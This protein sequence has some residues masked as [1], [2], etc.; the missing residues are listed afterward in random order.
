MNSPNRNLHVSLVS[1]RTPEITFDCVI[2]IINSFE[3]QK[4]FELLNIYIADVS[5]NGHGSIIKLDGLLAGYGFESGKTNSLISYYF[6]NRT[7]RLKLND[8][9]NKGFGFA[10]NSNFELIQYEANDK[11]VV[12]ILN[13]DTKIDSDCINHIHEAF[14]F[15]DSKIF[16]CVLIRDDNN[17][18]QCVGGTDE[19]SWKTNGK[20]VLENEHISCLEYSE[21]FPEIKG[22]INGA[23]I[24]LTFKSLSKIGF[25]DD[26]YFM[27][28]EEV[29]WCLKAKSFKFEFCAIKNAKV[30][31][32]VGGSSDSDEFK[33]FMGRKSKRN[34][35]SRFCIRNY[36]NYRNRI[37]LLNK[38]FP[39]YKVLGEMNIF[40]NALKSIVGVLL[41]DTNKVTRINLIFKGLRDG[42][43]NNMGKTIIPENFS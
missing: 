32:M 13:N 29:D 6:K 36:Y 10:N 40:I 12:W 7:I 31:H 30:Y 33:E 39:K 22:Y 16:G 43:N 35:L 25:F 20:L 8:V 41:Y 34:S 28:C 38:F 23:S 11:D 9:K 24:L 42:K 27:W 5:E 17:L 26:S 3:T 4:K 18:I 19:L 1:F 37:Y 2:S 14:K 15:N 21:T